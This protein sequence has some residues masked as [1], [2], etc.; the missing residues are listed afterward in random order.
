VRAV[1]RA[2]WAAVRRRR[3]QSL[4]VGVVVLLSSGTAVLALSLLV[5]SNGPFD[6]AFARQDGAH[7]TVG[8]DAGKATAAALAATASRPGVTAAS[9]PYDTV[10]ARLLAGS[11]PLAPGTVAGRQDAAGGVDELLLTDGRW[12]TGPGQIVL[13]GDTLPGRFGP[14]VGSKITVDVP[15]SPTLTVVGIAASVTKTAG[16]WVWPSQTDVLHAEGAARGR[17]MLY[18]FSSAGSA[19]AVKAS[20]AEATAGLPKGALVGSTTY[21]EAQLLAAERVKPMVPFVVAFGVLGLAMSVLIVVNVVAGAV[22]S[23]FR[24]IGVQ[25]ALG[26]TPAQ[27]VGV[28]AGQILA[29]CV[30]ACLLGVGLG[31]LLAQPLLA[32]TAE[33]YDVPGSATV[34]GWT[35]LAV[36]VGV[37]VI[38]GL[39]A[40]GPAVRGGRL[41]PVQALTVGRAPRIGRGFRI[42]RMLA[43]TR[44]PRS[45]SFGLG[46]PFA[47]PARA[48]VTL[49]AILLGATTVVFA[50]GLSSSLTRVV[51]AFDRT[52]AVPVTVNLMPPGGPGQSGPMPG[53]PRNVEGSEPGSGPGPE[54]GPGIGAAGPPITAAQAAAV[55]ADLEGRS[56]TARV[57][58]LSEVVVDLAGSGRSLSVRAYDGDASWTG[59]P[60]LS[61]RWY[62]GAGEAVA[63]SRT[64]RLTGLEVGDEITI[65][66][67]L[68]R[69]SVRIVGEV[70]GNGGGATVVMST[71]GLTGLV[72]D[73]T[74]DRFEVALTG[75]TDPGAYVDAA[76]TAL[77]GTAGV[78]VVTAEEQENETV[79][80]MI[81]VIATLT[82]LLS[83]VA[84]LG[85][86][87]TVVL[88]TRERVHEIGVLKSIGM[89]PRQVRLMVVTS[90]TAVG[91]L[92]GA[93]ALPAG[94][95]LHRWV[96]PVM[97]DSAGTGLPHDVL[98]VYR[99]G[100]LAVL[101]L[102]GV[103]LAVA[104][105]LVPAGWAARTR[106]ATALRAE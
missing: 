33:A 54:G 47:R 15:G 83:V 88:N 42:R 96:L 104:G 39:A 44:L 100:E 80:L 52:A 69:R 31:R 97:G 87:N 20:L 28:Y 12:L 92:A 59:Y 7:A 26:F 57:G 81:G 53:A 49:V 25:K 94:W 5:A 2:G 48:A 95:A 9:G 29:V 86:F 93:L 13:A 91:A 36:A 38:V 35:L 34:P 99:P 14:R 40:L 19:A 67:D 46:T 79:A 77:E 85:V 75:G 55:R 106:P 56:G 37:P 11:M 102:C 17:Q 45:V 27:V 63:T 8:F 72:T 82:L 43:A 21:Q 24:T 66:T 74:P 62:S 84:A 98:T 18:R 16:A 51:A 50:V 60:V 32:D 58:G 76:R 101:A 65:A 3:V 71:A 64:L 78:P 68:G 30:P 41:V 61:G 70:F 6:R 90:M 1:G 103:V 73:L 10:E 105:A 22:V 89:T 4:V 23:G